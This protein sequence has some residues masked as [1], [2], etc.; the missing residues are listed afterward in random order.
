MGLSRYRSVT[1]VGLTL[2]ARVGLR[3]PLHVAAS[4]ER[5]TASRVAALLLAVVLARSSSV[6]RVTV[7]VDGHRWSRLERSSAPTVGS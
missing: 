2:L 4:A 3:H 5:L 7:A 1:L 6:P